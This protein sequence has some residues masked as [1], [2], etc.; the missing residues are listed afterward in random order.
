MY[1]GDDIGLAWDAAQ[2][3]M[4]NYMAGY[5]DINGIII[6]GQAEAEAAYA[7]KANSYGPLGYDNLV[8]SNTWGDNGGTSSS[9]LTFLNEL[10]PFLGQASSEFANAKAAQESA[11]AAYDEVDAADKE[12]S[13]AAT[14]A[15]TDEKAAYDALYGEG[16][17]QDRYEAA[18][19]ADIELQQALRREVEATGLSMEEF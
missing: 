9:V 12:A 10:I 14:T 1:T 3:N 6:G 8:A 7:L 19:L 16:G 17:A 18:L 5:T 4:A 13:T 2:T 11:Q 15:T